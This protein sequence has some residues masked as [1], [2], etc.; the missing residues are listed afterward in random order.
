MDL[1]GSLRIGILSLLTV[2]LVSCGGAKNTIT[3]VK[4]NQTVVDEDI[5]LHLDATLDLGNILLPNF[6]G[7]ILIPGRGE[8]GQ[9]ELGQ[10][11]IAVDVNLSEIIPQLETEGELPNG[12][13]LPFI[14]DNPV[15]TLPIKGSNIEVYIS[16]ANGAPALGVSIPIRELDRIGVYSAF[17]P[18][19]RLDKLLVAGGIYSSVNAGE[20]GIGA[21]F[22]LSQIIKLKLGNE[23]Q[24][25]KGMFADILAIGDS[26]KYGISTD[27]ERTSRRTQKKI[28]R[29]LYKLHQERKTVELY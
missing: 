13:S 15:V 3:D 9:V 1:K 26:S 10:D 5:Y 8:V 11:F 29:V 6:A 23:P 25:E 2:F 27:T 28:D 21:F 18:A 24:E 20:S 7:P 14:K 17:F 4:V 12:A 16:L 19:F 22:D